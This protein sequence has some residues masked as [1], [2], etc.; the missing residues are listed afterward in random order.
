MT[1]GQCV[2]LVDSISIICCVTC[3]VSFSNGDRFSNFTD[4]EAV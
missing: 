1:V 2:K 4:A 3:I